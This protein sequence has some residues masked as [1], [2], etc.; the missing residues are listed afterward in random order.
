MY[1]L[2]YWEGQET[3]PGYFNCEGAPM[4]SKLSGR[5]R[6][7]RESAALVGLATGVVPSAGAQ[8]SPSEAPPKDTKDLIAYGERSHYVKSVRIPVMERMSPDEFGMTFHVLSPL[9][10]SV[11]IITAT[12]LHYVATHRG[13]YVPDINPQEHR[14]MIH[15]M[16]DRPLIFTVEELKRLPYVSRFHFIECIGNRAKP[17]DKTVQETHGMTSCAEWTGVLLSLLLKEAG[18]QNG[19]SWIVSEGAEEVKGGSSLPLAKALDDCLV[20]YG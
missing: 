4:S 19:A 2:D 18:V 9:Q 1:T 7:L 15:G 11:G 14:L 12:S 20:A 16:V 8:M 3:I 10:D 5:R 13:S 6:F 17:T